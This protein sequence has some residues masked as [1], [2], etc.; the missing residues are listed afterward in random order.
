MSSK[1]AEPENHV[2]PDA[3]LASAGNVDQIRDIIF[4]SQMRDYEGRFKRLEERLLNEVSSIR[5][6][7]NQRVESLEAFA[8]GEFESLGS[9]LAKERDERE[10][11][12]KELGEE[13]RKLSKELSRK[14]SHLDD[15]VAAQNRELR[16][17]LLSQSKSLSTDINATR[18]QLSEALT[19]A[20]GE[21]QHS[22]TDRAA[23]AEML[24][25]VALRL[26]D[27]FSLPAGN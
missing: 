16:E 19:Q 9:R 24:S 1:S 4:G 10:S 26:K 6:D 25:E 17:Q 2:E 22:K 21:L 11:D 12:D 7:V 18:D 14:I 8:R 3:D 20:T 5:N 15:S 23:L 13:I 27:E